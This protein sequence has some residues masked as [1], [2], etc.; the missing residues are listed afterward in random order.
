LTTLNEL[1][2]KLEGHL[3]QQSEN[4]DSFIYA[5][6]KG[7]YQG[8]DAIEIDG[9]RSTE[10]RFEQYNIQKYLSKKKSALDIGS[11]CGFFSLYVS[12]FLETIT[13][14]EI[15]P[16]LTLIASDTQEFLEIN[17]ANFISSKF[18]KF[19]SD[20]KFDIVFSFANDS[21]IDSN[22]D[23]NFGEYMGKIINLLKDDGLLIFESQ[24]ID[25]VIPQKFE[26]KMEIIKQFFT[27][28]EN[29]TVKSEYPLNVPERLFL[30]LKKK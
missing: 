22:T 4:W 27:I 1:H 25:I 3:N 19:S 21:T 16:Y 30:V 24:A 14:I 29:K 8:F 2:K 18:E 15:N 12:K 26:P 20:K 13:G 17:N 28:L 23:F 5:Q 10:K 7:F 6:E 9:C 11:N